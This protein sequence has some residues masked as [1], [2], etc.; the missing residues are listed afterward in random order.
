LLG[1]PLLK[2]LEK[3]SFK[4]EA[5]EYGIPHVVESSS[6]THVDW[7]KMREIALSLN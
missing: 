3:Y 5:D 1:T 4:E 6:Y 7:L 2:E